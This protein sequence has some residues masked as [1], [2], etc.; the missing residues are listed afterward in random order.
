[1]VMSQKKIELNEIK[2]LEWQDIYVALAGSSYRI[3][4]CNF[5]MGGGGGGKYQL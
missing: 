3:K 5:K 1:M 2:N 4:I